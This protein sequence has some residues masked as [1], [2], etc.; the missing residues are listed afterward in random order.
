MTCPVESRKLL[1]GVGFNDANY[2]VQRMRRVHGK[3]VRDWTC[4]YYQRWYDILRRCYNPKALKKRPNYQEVSVCESWLTFSNFKSW[5]VQQDWEGKVLDKDLR[6]KGSK[7]YSKDTC[8]FIS[9][10]VNTFIKEG[11]R[12]K[13][14]LRVGVSWHKRDE[15]YTA[16]CYDTLSAKL[17]HLG[18]HETELSAYTA[19]LTYKR[20]L[21]P[22]MADEGVISSEVHDLLTKWYV[23]VEN[24]TLMEGRP[25]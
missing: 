11:T 21:I 14:G 18:Y 7:I 22:R 23:S 25:L 19:Y 15:K 12:S 24:D 3:V 9:N 16:Q 13:N 8:I 4:P 10:Q 5:M 6:V 1:Y 20:D 17:K 2:P